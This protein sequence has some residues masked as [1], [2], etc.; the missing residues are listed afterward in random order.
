MT[1]AEDSTVERGRGKLDVTSSG[2]LSW[3]LTWEQ[4]YGRRMVRPL[5]QDHDMAGEGDGTEEL[6]SWPIPS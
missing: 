1:W 2:L 6:L 5:V 4:F 3:T